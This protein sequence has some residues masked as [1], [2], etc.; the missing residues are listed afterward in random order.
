ML[1]ISRITGDEGHP[2]YQEVA[3]NN[4]QRYYGFLQSIIRA[5]LQLNNNGMSE[6]LLK[7]INFHAI[8]GL[9]FEAGQ[10]R[11][12]DF[13]PWSYTPP[14]HVAVETLMNQA[15]V[16]INQSWGNASPTNLAAYT[17]WVINHIHPFV[18]GN[19]RTA[20][21]ACYYV[22][23]MKIGG[24]LPGSAIVP[25]Q[26]RRDREGYLDALRA[27]DNGNLEPV[28]DLVR[29]AVRAQTNEWIDSL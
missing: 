6:W 17:L 1:D 20:R 5:N 24:T 23:C 16:F 18:N 10:Y 7:A 22:L 14:S 2:V 25:E 3:A 27:G 19:G 15:V 29:E 8:A 11:T 4:Y 12:Y 28:T 26:L 13:P 21:A 9:R